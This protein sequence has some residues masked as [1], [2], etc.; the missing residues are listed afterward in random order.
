PIVELFVDGVS[1]GTT[2]QVS[3]EQRGWNEFIVNGLTQGTHTLDLKGTYYDGSSNHGPTIQII[4][5][6]PPPHADTV[7]L[8]QD[9]LL[10]GSQNLTWSDATVPGNAHVVSA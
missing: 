8:T 7:T 10:S 3:P 9:V 4:V 5:D 2:S 1:Q 6:A